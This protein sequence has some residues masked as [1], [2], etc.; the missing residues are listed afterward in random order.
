MNKSSGSHSVRFLEIGALERER[1]GEQNPY[2]EFL[3]VPSMSAGLYV[4]TAGST[5]KQSPHNQDEMYYVIRGRARMSAGS[6]DRPIN[7]G[8]LIFVAAT[9]EHRFYDIEQELAVLV[10]FAPSEG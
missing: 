5:D 10:F 2:L 8:T 9:V 7:E 3:R 1:I 6:E 4:L